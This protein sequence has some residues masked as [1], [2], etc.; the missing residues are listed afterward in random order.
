[1]T[2]QANPG[3]STPRP[4]SRRA[5]S[6]RPP[7]QGPSAQ[8]G[9]ADTLASLHGRIGFLSRR[10]VQV[11]DSYFDE[12]AQDLGLSLPQYDILEALRHR[13]TLAQL[14]LG[15]VLGLDPAN[16]AAILRR[17]EAAGLVARE[18]DPTDARRRLIRLTELGERIEA[19]AL[20]IAIATARRLLAPL[21]PDERV[22]LLQIL[23]SIADTEI[24]S[25]SRW[26]PEADAGARGDLSRLFE[27]PCFLFRRVNQ[28]VLSK[29]RDRNQDED[30]TARQYLLLVAVRALP[31]V[32]QTTLTGVLGLDRS[33]IALVADNLC[34]RKL[35]RRSTDPRDRRK[36]RLT[37]TPA[38]LAVADRVGLN[39]ADLE[40]ELLQGLPDSHGDAL[41]DMLQRLVRAHNPYVRSP[42]TLPEADPA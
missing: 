18:A 7:S 39:N 29:I 23:A 41:R 9:G 5:P 33:T 26:Q 36:N 14:A 15:Q 35:I 34:K 2:A 40:A 28:V 3:A 30:I 38:G 1:M 6:R 19:K 13:G 10:M 22:L 20:H 27:G 4:P 16:T 42:L 32:D 21:D 17:L 37:I 11:A 31:A 12:A 25:V 8:S 24:N